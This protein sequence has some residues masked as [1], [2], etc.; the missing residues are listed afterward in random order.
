MEGDG[1]LLEADVAGDARG[2]H[3]LEL[4]EFLIRAE[5][6]LGAFAFECRAELRE[7]GALGGGLGFERLAE[8]DDLTIVLCKSK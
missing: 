1:E 7:G 8:A 2:V 4:G 3:L 5:Q 6:A